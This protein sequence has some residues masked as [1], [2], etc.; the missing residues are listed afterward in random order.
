MSQTKVAVYDS[1]IEELCLVGRC[2]R[3]TLAVE[4]CC[5]IVWTVLVVGKCGY[6][7]NNPTAIVGLTCG[8]GCSVNNVLIGQTT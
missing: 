1:A 8:V 3:R 6:R 2:K 4:L 7:L 5:D